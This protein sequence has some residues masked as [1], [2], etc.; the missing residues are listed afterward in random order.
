[1]PNLGHIYRSTV[2]RHA[3]PCGVAPVALDHVRQAFSEMAKTLRDQDASI[4]EC[5]RFQNAIVQA[6][7]GAGGMDSAERLAAVNTL[8][9][10]FDGRPRRVSL[11]VIRSEF[12]RHVRLPEWREPASLVLERRR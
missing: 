4:E 6:I 2:N 7:N 10:A 12:L 11:R 8:L 3:L 1:M 5:E 9:T